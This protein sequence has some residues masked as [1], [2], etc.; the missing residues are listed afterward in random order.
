MPFST[1]SLPPT[2]IQTDEI[3]LSKNIRLT[4]ILNIVA[5]LI[6][7]LALW[8]LSVYTAWL[9]PELRFSSFAFEINLNTA[10]QILGILLL[11]FANLILHEAIHGIFFW[12][13]TGSKPLFALRLAYAYAAA[14]DWYISC[15]AYTIIGLAPLVLIDLISLLLVPFIP[16]HLILPLTLAVAFNT[17]GSVGDL[18]IILHLFR[19][20]TACLVNDCGDRV[21]YYEPGRTKV[22]SHQA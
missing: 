19:N 15:Q 3:D 2:Y 18:W 7:L 1:R 13:F 17:G 22:A 11:V 20:S 6:F 21:G 12:L 16:P 4:V 8:F 10:L 5:T 9:R 14:P